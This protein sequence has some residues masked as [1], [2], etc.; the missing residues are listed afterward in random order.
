MPNALM[1]GI[2]DERF[3]HLNPTKLTPYRISFERKRKLDL[4]DQESIAYLNGI[5]TKLAVSAAVLGGK[6]PN[7][8]IEFFVDINKNE[9]DDIEKNERLAVAE[10]AVW[11]KSLESQGLGQ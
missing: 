5:Y 10:M 4:K 3:P 1:Y 7:K 6:F 9:L 2:S 11:A 8:P